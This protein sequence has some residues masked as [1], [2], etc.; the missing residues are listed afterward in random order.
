VLV[1]FMGAGKTTVGQVLAPLL[2]WDFCD[3]DALV[4][5]RTGLSIA[6]LFAERGEAAFREQERRAAEVVTGLD[7][8]VVAAGGGA[9]AFEATRDLLRRGALTVWLR[10]DLEAIAARISGGATRPLAQDRATMQYLLA[11]REPAYRLADLVVDTTAVPAGEVARR[12]AAAV[13]RT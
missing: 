11:E 2:G 6:R 8:T 12:V 4:E 9:F 7:R 3:M 5:R 1:G 13:T 10:C